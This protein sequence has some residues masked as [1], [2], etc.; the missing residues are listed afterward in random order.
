MKYDLVFFDA[1]SPETQPE[2]W[3]EN[4]FREISLAMNEGG[5]LTTYS[6]KGVIKR[7]LKKVGFTIEPLPGPKGKREITRARLLTEE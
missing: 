1:F 5:I 4:I 7:L 6:A 2:L 3:S